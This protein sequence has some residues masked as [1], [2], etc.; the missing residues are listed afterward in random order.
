MSNY[1][2]TPEADYDLTE[3]WQYGY[4]KRGLKQANLYLLELEDFFE[5]ST[6]VM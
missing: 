3:I 6:P 4:K 5:I 2:L 1:Q